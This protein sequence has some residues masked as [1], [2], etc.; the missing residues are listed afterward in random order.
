MSARNGVTCDACGASW[1]I[2][3]AR[4]CGRCGAALPARPATVTSDAAGADDGD[5]DATGPLRGRRARA[6]VLVAVGLLVLAAGVGG[7]ATW[8][9]ERQTTDDGTVELPDAA[10]LPAPAT[11]QPSQAG[12]IPEGCELWRVELE[13][14]GSLFPGEGFVVHT[15]MT[16]EA[17]GDRAAPTNQVATV[18]VVTMDG[19]IAWT[20]EVELAPTRMFGMPQAWSS[21]DLILV[22]TADGLVAHGVED[23][24]ARWVS[25]DLPPGGFVTHRTYADDPIVGVEA[26][27]SSRPE[28]GLDPSPRVVL[29]RLDRATGAPMWRIDDVTPR[30]FT[31]GLVFVQE[32]EHGPVVAVALSTGERLWERSMPDGDDGFVGG[33]PQEADGRVVLA[34]RGGVEVVDAATGATL[35]ELTDVPEPAAPIL[36]AGSLLAVGPNH[37]FTGD[38]SEDVP[39]GSVALIDLDSYDPTPRWIEDVIWVMPL[40]DGDVWFGP[41]LSAEVEGLAILSVADD[42]V[43][44]QRLDPDGSTRWSHRWEQHGED[45]CPRL[46]PGLDAAS[47]VLAPQDPTTAPAR[48][49]ATADGEILDRVR[50][51]ADLSR[52]GFVN[53]RGPIATLHGPPAQGGPVIVGPGG[54]FSFGSTG[55]YS[56]FAAPGALHVQLDTTLIALDLNAL[57]G[58][59][60]NPTPQR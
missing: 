57:L 2:A 5:P 46:H 8:I 11:P 13:G 10:E 30:G 38:G 45:C 35:L 22:P 39:T 24:E 17:R 44:L 27:P 29:A 49:I 6:A 18:T 28:P 19:A 53:W 21:G 26:E 56:M 42:E 59:G 25:R 20:R 36:L 40:F 37:H 9:E 34:D 14:E 54:R 33:W 3:T 32:E 15:T 16:P 60:G 58:P 48:I 43:R 41:F 7:T 52:L 50:L 47:V 31:R 1:D 12:C 23:G 4:Y 51:P 55:S